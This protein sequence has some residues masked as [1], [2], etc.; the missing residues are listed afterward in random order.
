[1]VQGTGEEE[2]HLLVDVPEEVRCRVGAP[3]ET[4]VFCH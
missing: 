4:P 1:M 2:A 3:E